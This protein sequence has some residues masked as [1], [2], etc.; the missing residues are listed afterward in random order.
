M[1]VDTGCAN[2]P[3]WVMTLMMLAFFGKGF[4]SI[5]RS[6][7]PSLAPLRLVILTGGYL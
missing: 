6:M 7:A 5:T 4:A 2:D 3:V 1:P